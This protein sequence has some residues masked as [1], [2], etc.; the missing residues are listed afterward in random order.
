[1]KIKKDEKKLDMEFPFQISEIN[2]TK[3]DDRREEFHWHSFFEITYIQSGAAAYFVSEKTYEVVAGDFVI[4]NH[5]EPHGWEIRGEEMQVLV[6][7]FSGKLISDRVGDF[8]YDYL[9]PFVERGSN[10]KNK[11]AQDNE[12]SRLMAA[13]TGEIYNEWIARA[14]GYKLMVKADILKLLTLLTR[15]Y[16]D[17]N[18]P[19]ENLNEKKSG[20]KRLEGVLSYMYEHFAE[21]ITLEDMAKQSF[22]SPSYFSAYFKKVTGSTFSEYLAGIRIREVQRLLRTTSTGIVEAAMACGFHNISNFYRIYK[23]YT[24]KNPSEERKYM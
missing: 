16:T 4:F 5:T 22:M 14:S 10:F 6:M 9:E 19:V 1:M 11:I 3:A 7:M 12:V 23:K 18:K 17:T 20:M 24:G 15:H 13:L 21:K 2:L 8:D